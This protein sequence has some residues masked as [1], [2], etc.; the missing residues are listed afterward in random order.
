MM[1]HL[2]F[3]LALTALS[4]PTIALG[5]GAPTTTVVRL[6]SGGSAVLLDGVA[7]NASAANRTVT[8][9]LGSGDASWSKLVFSIDYTDNA[10]TKVEAS[11]SCDLGDGT[12]TSL[13]SRNV[14]AGAAIVSPLV[15]VLCDD[16]GTACDD[17]T[18]L[19]E[20]DARGCERFRLILSD[21]G[22]SCGASD[23]V[24]VYATAV[25]GY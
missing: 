15:D 12:F 5:R 11:P 6:S 10:C 19:L 22:S 25:V 21:G 20:Y 17:F 1:R 2:A 13:V 9:N 18:Y 3:I 7:M 16:S 23:L 14:S 4:A 8:V 24:T